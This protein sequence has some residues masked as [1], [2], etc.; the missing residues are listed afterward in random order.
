M[1]GTFLLLV[2]M[3]LFMGAVIGHDYGALKDAEQDAADDLDFAELQAWLAVMRAPMDVTVIYPV[4][5]AA[6]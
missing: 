2:A 3:C 4:T 1:T 5:E 6:A